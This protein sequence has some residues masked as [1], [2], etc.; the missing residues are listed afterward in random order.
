MD[1]DTGVLKGTPGNSDVGQYQIIVSVSDGN[2]GTGNKEYTLSVINVDDPAMWTRVPTDTVLNKGVAYSFDVDAIE[3]DTGVTPVFSISSSPASSI[4]INAKT[5]VIDWVPTEYGKYTITI[6]FGDMANSIY[7]TFIITVNTP[8]MVTLAS[9]LNGTEVEVINPTFQWSAVDGDEDNVTSNLYYGTDEAGVRALGTQYL[10]GIGLKDTYYIP[11]VFLEKGKKYYWTVMPD[12]GRIKGNCASGVWSFSVNANATENAPPRFTSTPDL[13]TKVGFKWT[14]GPT[15]SDD[16]PT[17]HVTITLVSGPEGMTLV[18][19]ML[20]WIPRDDQVGIYKVK[21]Q[22]SDGKSAIYQEFSIT[23]SKI[24]SVN[25]PPVIDL[26]GPIKVQ[27]GGTIS[28]KV[29]A[30]DTDGDTVSFE[31]VSGPQGLSI[32]EYGQLVWATKKGD[33]GNYDVVVRASDGKAVD[34]KTITVKVE[35]VGGTTSNAGLVTIL[36]VLLVAIMVVIIA[37]LVIVKSRKRQSIPEEPTVE[38]VPTKTTTSPTHKNKAALKE[39][40]L[41]V[42][43]EPKKK[44][45]T[46]KPVEENVSIP[47]KTSSETP[48]KEPKPKAD[49]TVAVVEAIDIDDLED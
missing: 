1:P 32:N 38:V 23:V 15:A 31:L 24:S 44:V 13:Q 18:A 39:G 26:V 20:N 22:A 36:A 35:K 30:T 6:S 19:G 4:T 27:E 17:D 40:G 7:H 5:G 25:H 49:Q 14:Y 33:A 11:V 45:V 10:K 37:V 43:P 8:P 21:L 12:D 3:P 34:N 46:L 9:P 47:E 42:N 29:T 41:K 28:I 48:S 2:G 16:D